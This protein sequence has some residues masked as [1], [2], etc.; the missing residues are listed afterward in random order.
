MVRISA[1]GILAFGSS[2]RDATSLWRRDRIVKVP[3]GA[4]KRGFKAAPLSK[5]DRFM[6]RPRSGRG[7]GAAAAVVSG[8]A[9][10]AKRRSGASV[11]LMTAQ[12]QSFVSLYVTW[13]IQQF[14]VLAIFRRQAETIVRLLDAARERG[15]A[16]VYQINADADRN[17]NGNRDSNDCSRTART[18]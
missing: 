6:A 14:I 2:A 3:F 7:S 16:T 4:S 18:I 9:I 12:R 11:D 5:S 13:R 8:D 15:V 10:H 17:S 1:L